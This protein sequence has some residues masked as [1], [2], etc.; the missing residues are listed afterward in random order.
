MVNKDITNQRPK[1]PSRIVR[2]IE[3]IFLEKKLNNWAGALL[4]AFVAIFMGYLLA[5][6]TVVGIGVFGIAVGLAVVIICL[7]STEAG[8]YINLVYSFFVYHFSRFAFNDAIPVGVITD[9]LIL[10][11]LFSLFIKG[12]SLRKSLNEFVHTP[13]VIW[14][15]ML[16][17]YLTIQLFNPYGHS[18]EAWLQTVRRSLETLIFLFIA[19]QILSKKENIRKYLRALFVVCTIA[20]LYGC[21][22]QWHGLFDFER[23][24]VMADETRFGL[25]FIGGEFRKFSTFNDPTAFGIVMASCSVFY[26]IIALA[27]PNK[28]IKRI[29]LGGV[30]IM[31]LGMAYS[32][33]RTANVMLMA[34][35]VM[36]ILLSFH[37]RGTR[38]FAFIGAILFLIV[39][40]IPIYSNGTINRFRSSFAGSEDE[41]YKVREMSRA[42]IRPYIHSHPIG[43]GLETTGA[44]G[45][46]LNPGHYL[47][48]FQ[49]DSGY[50]KIALETG[51]IGLALICILFFFVLKSGISGYFAC[52]K[53]DTRI[54]YA[55]ATSAIFCFYVGEF[56]QDAI[57]QVTDMV[58]YY[59]IIAI[60]LK[61]RYVDEREV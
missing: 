61:L 16:Y 15:I 23:N 17:F 53:E 28:K 5:R 37:K 25:V 2:L 31:I 58:V 29:L 48:G 46:A 44:H 34:G 32:G 38:V 40:Y 3:R 57:G 56:A 1:L 51:W 7:L 26:T 21:I 52:R 39:M 24:W 6:Q 14:T 20:G 33:T 36:F 43:G 19:Y 45:V 11:M 30:I 49:T 8:F 55:A 18:V 35:F 41:S 4:F 22:Q 9:V 42:F 60:M 27:E 10:S 13:V 54:V 50:L 59:P 12:A 47:A